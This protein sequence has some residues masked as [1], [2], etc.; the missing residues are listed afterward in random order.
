MYLYTSYHRF[1]FQWENTLTM[2]FNK[3]LSTNI[4]LY[5]RFDDNAKRVDN[6]SYWQFKEYLSVG[7]SYSL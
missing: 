4:Y 6:M 1:E 5:P 7:F 2:Q 3:F